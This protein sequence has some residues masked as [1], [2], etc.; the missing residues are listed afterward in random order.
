MT[1]VSLG[2][3][4]VTGISLG[5]FP[6]AR[7]RVCCRDGGLSLAAVASWHF[8]ITIINQVMTED[9]EE[10]NSKDSFAVANHKFTVKRRYKF[11]LHLFDE[12]TRHVSTFRATG[13]FVYDARHARRAVIQPRLV[14]AESLRCNLFFGG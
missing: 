2:P 8:T 12:T 5:P 9:T 6:A 13:V 7:W 14:P 4:S 1:G 10:E 3:S 11:V